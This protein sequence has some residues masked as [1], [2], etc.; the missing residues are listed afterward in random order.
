MSTGFTR[1][2]YKRNQLNNKDMDLNILK[3]IE[4][5]AQFVKSKIGA[6]GWVNWQKKLKTKR[7]YHTIRYHIL[8]PQL[9]LGIKEI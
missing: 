6:V 9:Q 3:R 2:Y 4:E 8:P 1:S 7:L 5:A